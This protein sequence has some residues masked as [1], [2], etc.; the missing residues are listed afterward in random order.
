M[1]VAATLAACV[2]PNQVVAGS[3]V[4]IAT[5][6][7]VRGLN[8]GSTQGQ[9]A[10][11]LGVDLALYAGFTIIDERGKP[12]PDL[13]FGTMRVVAEDPLTVRYTVA[14]ATRWSDG[15][16]VDGVDLLLDWAAHSGRWPGFAATIGGGAGGAET[17]PTLSADRKSLTVVFDDAATARPELQ[18]AAPMPAHVVATHALGVAGTEVAK[19]A[20]IA[21]VEAAAAGDDET[22]ARLAAFWSGRF[23]TNAPPEILVTSGPYGVAEAAHGVLELRPNAQYAG[24][25]RPRIQSVRIVTLPP[26]DGLQALTVNAAD[27]LA[28]TPS[29]EV[30]ELVPMLGLRLLTTGDRVNTLI[31]VQ[32][33]AVGGV[34]V[35]ADGRRLLWNVS[36]WTPTR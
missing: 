32:R 30:A 23:V 7:A 21:A 33:Q 22:L 36:E 3:H 10:A 5:D 31:A 34:E 13:S 16:P 29:D 24:D 8:P 11:R 35:G 12:V 25:R 6:S 4:T 28:V 15:T 1:A 27:I 14:D 17:L 9:A 18:F 19:D 26:L 20:V 2:A